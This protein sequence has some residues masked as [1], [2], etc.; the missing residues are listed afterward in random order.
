[1]HIERRAKGFEMRTKGAGLTNGDLNGGTE[2]RK[3]MLAGVRARSREA[4]TRRGHLPAESRGEETTPKEDNPEEQY[5]ERE[6]GID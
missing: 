4:A 3:Q 2:Q 6:T 5:G 1:M